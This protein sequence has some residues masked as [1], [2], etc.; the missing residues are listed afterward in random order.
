MTKTKMSVAVAGAI[1]LSIASPALALS[2]TA[3]STG[4]ITAYFY[5]QSAAYGSSLGLL[6][7]GVSTGIVG[8]QNHNTPQGT[9]IV[10]GNATA[11]DILTFQLGVSTSDP[12]GPPPLSYY[13]YSDPTLNSDSQEHTLASAWAGGPGLIPAGTFVGFEDIIPLNQSDLDYNDHQ[14]VFTNVSVPDGGSTLA[15]AGVSLM[16]LGLLR[17]RIA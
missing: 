7:N 14:F 15:L 10:L 6:I 12:N 5:G 2:F 16:A 3:T 4:P 9:S 11:G 8:L 17:R 13:L 1:C